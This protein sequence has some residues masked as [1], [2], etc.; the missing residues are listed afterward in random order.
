MKLA[1]YAVV[2]ALIYV[3]PSAASETLTPEPDGSS[4]HFVSH[5]AVEI[6]SPAGVVWSQ[7][8]DVGSWMYEFELPLEHR[9]VADDEVHLLLIERSGTRNTGNVAN[10]RTTTAVR[11]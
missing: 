9:P 2:A 11:A 8:I 3:S 10:E 7:L 4:Y 5:Y 6:D 1:C